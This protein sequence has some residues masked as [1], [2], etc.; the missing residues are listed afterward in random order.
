MLEKEKKKNIVQKNWFKSTLWIYK[1]NSTAYKDLHNMKA[2]QKKICQCKILP[3]KPNFLLRKINTPKPFR[4]KYCVNKETLPYNLL[5]ITRIYRHGPP[6][7]GH[8][9]YSTHLV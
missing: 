6:S 7:V 1:H 3:K 4:Q 2:Q 9:T 5:I 8:Y